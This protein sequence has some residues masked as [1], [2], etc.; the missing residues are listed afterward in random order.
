MVGAAR[1]AALRHDSPRLDLVGVVERF[2]ETLLLLADTEARRRELG[3]PHGGQAAQAAA[4][5]ASARD[6]ELT[7]LDGGAR[8]PPTGR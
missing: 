4:R 8:L 7:A 2:E 1:L 6:E 5:G 3:Q